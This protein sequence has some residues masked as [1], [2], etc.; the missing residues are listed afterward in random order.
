MVEAVKK[1]PEALKT[2]FADGVSYQAAKAVQ[3]KLRDTE[4]T[5]LLGFSRG[6]SGVWAKIL[7]AYER[8][9]KL[10]PQMHTKFANKCHI[11]KKLSSASCFCADL[12]LGEAA[13]VLVRNGE[14]EIPFH[15]NRVVKEQQQLVDLEKKEVEYRKSVLE[16]QKAYHQV[17]YS[18]VPAPDDN[19]V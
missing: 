13:L 18:M 15:K 8:D 12:H 5:S 11:V 7:K 3:E 10:H 16:S 17:Q 2:E 6:E 19:N 4:Q 14:F 9:S 1:L